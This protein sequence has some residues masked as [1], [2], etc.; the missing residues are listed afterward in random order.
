VSNT[1]RHHLDRRVE[2]LI[3]ACKGS[4]DEL[5]NTRAVAALLGVSR[6]WLEIGRSGVVVKVDDAHRERR[7][8][9][10]KFVRLAPQVI[11]YKRGDVKAWLL[12]R[13][14][15]STAEYGNR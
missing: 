12:E 9:G 2:N 3:A 8:Y 1:H 7:Y 11:R 15:A 14:Y 10:P 13:Q 5:L 6:Q 4:D